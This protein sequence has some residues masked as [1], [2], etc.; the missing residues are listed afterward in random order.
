[1]GQA[2]KQSTFAMKACF[3]VSIVP[4]CVSELRG[5]FVGEFVNDEGGCY[6]CHVPVVGGVHCFHDKHGGFGTRD[7]VGFDTNSMV[8][9]ESP[10]CNSWGQR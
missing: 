3:L 5:N 6:S 10:V 2:V 9:I 8:G 4:E 7:T 1:M